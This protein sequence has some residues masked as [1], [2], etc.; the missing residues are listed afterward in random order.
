MST[1]IGS[2]FPYREFRKRYPSEPASAVIWQWNALAGELDATEHTEYGTLT[3]STPGGAH[4]IVPGTAMTFQIVKPGKRTTS[5]SHSWWHLYFVRSGSGSVISDDLHDAAELNAG[6]IMLIPAW[7]VHHFENRR[8]QE[9]LVLLNIS[10]LP[11]QA[12]LRNLL[13]K[14]GKAGDETA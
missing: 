11:Q 10:N 8:A 5:H 1:H 9:D 4:E 6:D 2:Q 14:E 12:D 3:L 13:S 7:S